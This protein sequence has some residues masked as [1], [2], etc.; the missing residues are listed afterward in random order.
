MG[1][2]GHVGGV[3][4]AETALAPYPGRQQAFIRRWS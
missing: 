3:K 2:P 4:L 1:T